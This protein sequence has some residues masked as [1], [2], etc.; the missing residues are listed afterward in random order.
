MN[1]FHISG[2]SAAEAASPGAKPHRARQGYAAV[3]RKT[4]VDFLLTSTSFKFIPPC[5]LF[6][7][8]IDSITSDYEYYHN[9]GRNQKNANGDYPRIKQVSWF[10]VLLKSEFLILFEIF[11]HFPSHVPIVDFDTTL[12]QIRRNHI[13]KDTVTNAT[14]RS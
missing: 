2:G 7:R 4:N 12:G 1:S 6:C 14:N 5:S 9:R 3:I 11:K 10:S 13:G 8:V